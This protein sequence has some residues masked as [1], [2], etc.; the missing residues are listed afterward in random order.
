VPLSCLSV[1]RAL[2][3]TSPVVNPRLSYPQ[4]PAV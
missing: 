2:M 3:F 1:H 4:G